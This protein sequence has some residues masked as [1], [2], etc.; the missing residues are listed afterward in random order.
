M[1]TWRTPGKYTKWAR[2]PPLTEEQHDVMLWLLGEYGVRGVGLYDFLECHA[3]YVVQ[4]RG[5][6]ALDLLQ[7][8]VS[9]ERWGMEEAQNLFFNEQDKYYDLKLRNYRAFLAYRASHPV[10]GPVEMVIEKSGVEMWGVCA[11]KTALCA[12]ILRPIPWWINWLP[13]QTYLRGRYFFND[14]RLITAV[15]RL[16]SIPGTQLVNRTQI[17]VCHSCLHEK[18]YS[19]EWRI[20][21]HKTVED[22]GRLE[23]PDAACK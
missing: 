9:G 17:N 6:K 13:W 10:P 19:K 11:V 22:R 18:L 15:W 3:P 14:L 4:N 1:K 23:S 16:D 12:A 5:R 21:P 7:R 2:N 20:E 8:M